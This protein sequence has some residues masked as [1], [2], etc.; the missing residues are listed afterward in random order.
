MSTKGAPSPAA[1]ASPAAAN[2]TYGSIIPP[3]PASSKLAGTQQQML[4]VVDLMKD[5]IRKAIDRDENLAQLE[6][7]ADEARAGASVFERAA[8]RLRRQLWWKN[9]KLGITIAVVVGIVIAA[10]VVVA[11]FL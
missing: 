5:N 11:V 10:I 4:E 2:P 8:S 6:I 1:R 7:K 3:G 9:A